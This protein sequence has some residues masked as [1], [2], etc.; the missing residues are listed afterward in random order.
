MRGWSAILSVI[1]SPAIAGVANA[2]DAY[3]PDVQKFTERVAMCTEA[4]KDRLVLPHKYWACDRLAIDRA[5]LVSRY[6]ENPKL[7]EALDG[8]WHVEVRIKIPRP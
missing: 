4:T 7:V 1:V 8:H 2:P 6:R 5:R 3:P